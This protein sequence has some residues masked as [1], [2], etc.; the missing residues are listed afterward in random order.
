MDLLNKYYILLGI[1]PENTVN[2]IDL[3]VLSNPDSIPITDLMISQLDERLVALKA[4]NVVLKN[5][6]LCRMKE[7][8]KSTDLVEK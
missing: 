3:F 2:K 5:G 1:T 8:S 4:V 6:C 7:Y